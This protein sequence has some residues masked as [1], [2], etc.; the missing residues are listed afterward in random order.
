[1]GQKEADDIPQIHIIELCAPDIRTN[2][3]G[4]T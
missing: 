4:E 1:M 3:C 2:V